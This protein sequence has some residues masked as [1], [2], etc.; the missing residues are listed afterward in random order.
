MPKFFRL[1][2]KENIYGKRADLILAH[3][4]E[5]ERMKELQKVLSKDT[6]SS[7]LSGWKEA[8]RPPYRKQIKTEILKKFAADPSPAI[9]LQVAKNT[10][11]PEVLQMLIDDPCDKVAKIALPRYAKFAKR[12]AYSKAYHQRK[13]S[14]PTSSS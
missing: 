7:M 6:E 8:L 13:Q 2:W 12:A 10:T 4:D 14:N 1:Y 3:P 5:E 11:N 9:R